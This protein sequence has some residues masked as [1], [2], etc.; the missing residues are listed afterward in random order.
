VCTELRGLTTSSETSPTRKVR[1][2]GQIWL[3]M[4]MLAYGQKAARPSLYDEA[5]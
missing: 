5:G 4:L 3:C 2:Q 1:S